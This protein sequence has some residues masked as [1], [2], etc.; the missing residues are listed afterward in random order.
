MLL[1]QYMKIFKNG[2]T[3]KVVEFSAKESV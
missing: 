1:F 2:G 3:K